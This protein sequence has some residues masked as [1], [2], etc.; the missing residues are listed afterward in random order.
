MYITPFFSVII[1]A[2]HAQEHIGEAIQS[3]LSQ[4][5]DQFEIIV[6]DDESTDHTVQFVKNFRDERIICYSI[7]H[8][9]TQ[10]ARYWGITHAKGTYLIF[11]DADDR[12][13]DNALESICC[14]IRSNPCDLYIGGMLFYDKDGLCHEINKEIPGGFIDKE[15]LF[16]LMTDKRMIKTLARKVLKREVA[17]YSEALIRENTMTYGEDMFYSMDVLMKVRTIF[18]SHDIMYEYI[19]RDHG[20]MSRFCVEKYRD[21]I[22]M[23]KAILYYGSMMG[24]GKNELDRISE[25]YL[26]KQLADCLIEIDHYGCNNWK[27]DSRF[28]NEK[29]EILKILIKH[30]LAISDFHEYYNDMQMKI[31]REY[32]VC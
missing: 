29:D 15:D 20:T 26:T 8:V 11:L 14:S 7:R 6:I 23:Y 1:P 21:R 4:K 3:V 24:I 12:L 13:T 32:E 28:E 31:F 16:R 18:V 30:S 25:V 9:G 19:L 5:Y 2:Y 10:Q 22:L 27:Y 17:L